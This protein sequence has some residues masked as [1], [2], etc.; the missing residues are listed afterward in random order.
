[1]LLEALFDL[2]DAGAQAQAAE[3]LPVPPLPD[4]LAS[5]APSGAGQAPP[6]A[7]GDASMAVWEATLRHGEVS[8]SKLAQLW[9]G[10][11][12]AILLA[13]ILSYHGLSLEVIG[14][15]FGVHKTPGMRWLSPLAPVN[16]QGA[17]QQSKR[18]F[19]GTVAVDEKWLKVAG[20]W[21]SLFVA[22]DHVAGF[23]LHVALLPSN[24]TPY[25]ALF[26]LPLN[27]LGY[28]PQVIITDGWDA[29]GKAIARVFPNAQHLLCRF[30]A[31]R[32]ALRRLRP[33]VPS[34][35]ARRRWADTLKALFRT[36][37]KR[38]VQRRLDT[39]QSEA[40]GSP[41]QAVVTRLLAKL[42]QLLP[43][44]GSTWRPTTSNAAERFLGAFDRFY[45]AK[46]P[47]Q[48]PASAQKHVDLCM[49]GYVFETFSAEAAAERQGRCPLQVAGYNVEAIPLFHVLNRPNPSRLRHASAAGYDL[50]A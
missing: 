46:G 38:T 10:A 18:F 16:W 33:Q 22:V 9:D 41:A 40:H 13:F 15:F 5:V 1:M 17:V 49:L 45:R 50:A 11:T 43:A 2:A 24:A 7:P 21:W 31:L 14:R 37:S 26:L 36:P 27:A 39:L 19:S 48:N 28:H 29:Y 25:C 23:P 30:H 3:A 34:G 4:R 20:V 35:N 47:L 32:A 8:P 42:P 6:E 12:G 44:V